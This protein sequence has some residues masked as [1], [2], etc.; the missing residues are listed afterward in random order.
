[1]RIFG[2]AMM[3]I[4]SSIFCKVFFR[5]AV[6]DI[7]FRFL[8]TPLVGSE[9]FWLL[10]GDVFEVEKDEVGVVCLFERERCVE[11]VDEDEGLL[12]SEVYGEDV[13]FVFDNDVLEPFKPFE[14]P[15]PLK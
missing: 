1:M 11:R 8:K 15:R 13:P 5:S 6:L 2:L 9:L 3:R 10:A 12:E 4:L 7:V 14:D